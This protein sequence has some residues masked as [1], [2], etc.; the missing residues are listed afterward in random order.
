MDYL[1]KFRSRFAALAVFYV[2][3][4]YMLC[5]EC[6]AAW[7]LSDDKSQASIRRDILQDPQ[8]I[9]GV[10]PE[11][12]LNKLFYSSNITLMTMHTIDINEYHSDA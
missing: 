4:I 11:G 10:E 9:P 7:W 6:Y 8:N 3:D 1:I 5:K 12:L 2:K